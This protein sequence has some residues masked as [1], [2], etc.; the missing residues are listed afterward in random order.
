M[1]LRGEIK[2][3]GQ[4]F[5]MYFIVTRDRYSAVWLMFSNT[6]SRLT[7]TEIFYFTSQRLLDD[8]YKS[9]TRLAA[10]G[11]ACRIQGAESRLCLPGPTLSR[12]CLDVH[13][14]KDKLA[15]NSTSNTLDHKSPPRDGSSRLNR[16]DCALNRNQS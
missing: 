14:R 7:T 10:A 9:G 15:S 4:I 2:H 1:V 5:H 16:M 13:L 6:T 3:L 8:K 11:L 12:E